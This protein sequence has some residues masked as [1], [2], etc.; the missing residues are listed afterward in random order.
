MGIS[1]TR[2][3]AAYPDLYSALEHSWEIAFNEWLPALGVQLDSF[4]SYPHLRNLENHLDRLLRDFDSYPI[5]KGAVLLTPIELYIVLSSILFHDIG[6]IRVKHDHGR[7]SAKIIREEYHALGIVSEELAHTIARICIFHDVPPAKAEGAM[8]MLSTIAVDPYGEIR[9][10]GCAAL[11]TL[12]DHLDGA[13]TRVLPEYI[14]SFDQIETIG[15]FRKVV[16]GV[17]MDLTGQMVKVVLGA[18]IWELPSKPVPIQFAINGE[19][20]LPDYFA[21]TIRNGSINILRKDGIKAFQNVPPLIK[22]ICG[23]KTKFG[24][25]EWGIARQ[26][27]FLEKRSETPNGDKIICHLNGTPVVNNPRPKKAH[28]KKAPLRDECPWKHEM[29][30]A[31]LLGN[32]RENAES[33][34]SIRGILSALGIPIRQWFLEFDEHLFNEFGME[35]CEPIF[36]KDYLVEVAQNMWRLSTEVFGQDDFSYETLAGQMSEPDVERIRRAV[37]RLGILLRDD[38]PNAHLRTRKPIDSS[39]YN[40]LWVGQNRWKWQSQY[41][42]TGSEKQ[43]R[44]CS[45]EDVTIRVGLLAEPTDTKVME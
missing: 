30:L 43:C 44:F 13:F 9:E 35:T 25:A 5:A 20:D 14:K 17:E 23:E 32:T 1:R 33:V 27:F 36:C 3:Q 26:L 22:G 10:R 11:L 2:L 34:R 24:I 6:R 37:R 29:L 16:R 7:E 19:R 38:A 31:V 18:D 4:N 8:A 12:F 15:A 42:E 41:T 28:P 45:L 21:E 39:T 40:A